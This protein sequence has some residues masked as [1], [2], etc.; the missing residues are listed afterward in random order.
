MNR[1]A[2]GPGSNQHRDKPPRTSPNPPPNTGCAAASTAAASASPFDA[3]PSD[4]AS[5]VFARFPVTPDTQRRVRTVLEGGG[6][7]AKTV[8]KHLDRA[9][10]LADQGRSDDAARELW[11]ALDHSRDVS[12]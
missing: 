9:D 12:S 3:E 11:K 10:T 5:R 4:S 7:D 2:R 1:A 6:K 8:Q